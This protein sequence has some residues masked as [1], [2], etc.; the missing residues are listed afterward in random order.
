MNNRAVFT[1][2]GLFAALFFVGGCGSEVPSDLPKLHPTV[3]TITQGGQPLE[4]ALVT[5]IAEETGGWACA[6][7]TD[8]A[9]RAVIKTNGMYNGA[10]E[11]TYKVTIV[12]QERDWGEDPYADAPDP[13]SPEYGPWYTANREKIAEA[14]RRPTVTY[15]LVDPQF[16]SAARTTLEVTITSGRNQHNLDV[17]DTART[18]YKAEIIR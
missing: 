6:G 7:K 8:S 2:M 17:G 15:D 5:M 11:G 4:G 10:P 1:W 9:G 12:K 13:S 3:I 18:E 14:E 16:S